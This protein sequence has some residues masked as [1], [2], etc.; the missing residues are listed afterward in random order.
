MARSGESEIEMVQRHAREGERHAVRQR[1]IVA[2]LPPNTDLAET[3]H[4]LLKLFEESLE[5]HREH[6]ARLL[7]E[8]PEAGV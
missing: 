6:L 4:Q 2:S 5:N 3:A 7:R 8:E 1:E